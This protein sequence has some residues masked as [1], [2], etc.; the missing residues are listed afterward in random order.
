M[1]LHWRG[2]GHTRPKRTRLTRT[3]AT[4]TTVA[5]AAVLALGNAAHAGDPVD[6][7]S[8]EL[9]DKLFVASVR[10]HSQ[11]NQ[12]LKDLVLSTEM[13]GYRQLHPT[14]TLDQMRDHTAVMSQWY[15]S[16]LTGTDAAR[17]AYELLPHMLNMIALHPEA[18]IAAPIM[19]EL[20]DTVVS[21]DAKAYGER[22]DQVATAQFEYDQ[23]QRLYP[24]QDMIWRRI[25]ALA[26]QDQSFSAAWDGSFGAHLGVLS[27]ASLDQ[28]AADPMIS[29]YLNVDAILAHQQNTEQYLAEAKAQLLNA[30]HR[31]EEQNTVMV[32]TVG[33]LNAA[34][35]AT[36]IGPRPDTTVFNRERD[37]AAARQKIID[38]AGSAV[39]VLAKLIGYVDAKSGRIAA[40]LGKAAVQIATSINKYIP[41]IAGLS[42]GQALTSMST[43]ALTG[44][45][46]G[47]IGALLPV[48][49]EQVTPEQMIMDQIHQLRQE[50]GALATTMQSRF[51]RVEHALTVVYTDM[52]DKFD[53]VI[54]LQNATLAQL[55]ELERG[56]YQLNTTVDNWGVQIMQSLQ[57]GQLNAVK[58]RINWGI[59]HKQTYGEPIQ[60]YGDYQTVE[61][62]LHLMATDTAFNP[63]FAGPDASTYASQNPM[64]VLQTYQAKGAVDYLDWYARQ[65]FGWQAPQVNQPADVVPWIVAARAY[66][67]LVAENPTYARQVNQ[68][69]TGSILGAGQGIINSTTQ[70][71]KPLSTPD[72]N[73]KRTNALFTGLSAEYRAALQ[74]FSGQL[75]AIRGTNPGGKTYNMFGNGDQFTAATLPDAAKMSDPTKVP[76][77]TGTGPSLTRPSTVTLNGTPASL[78]FAQYAHPDAPTVKLCYSGG[79][80]NVETYD[81]IKWHHE[82]ADLQVI[83][84]V[85]VRWAGQEYDYRAWSMTWNLGEVCR[86]YLSGAPG[87]FCRNS[88][89]YLNQWDANY[90]T[91]FTNGALD[92]ANYSLGTM[93]RDRMNEYLS[94][95]Q[96]VYYDRVLGALGD[97]NSA[98]F[99]AD[100]RLSKA[101]RLIQAYTQLGFAKALIN[102]DVLAVITTGIER[103]PTDLDGVQ[104]IT[105][106]FAKAQA[107]YAGCNPVTPGGA[108]APGTGTFNPLA[109]QAYL[110]TNCN[111]GNPAGASGDPIG[112]CVLSI[113]NVRDAVYDQRIEQHSQEL[114][115]G[116]YAEGLPDV[117]AILEELTL[118]DTVVRR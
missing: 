21:P 51:D 28:L 70:F 69:R 9:R 78:L 98:L 67:R 117:L 46:I 45:I 104:F 108:C 48:F 40:G 15:D 106:S 27:T 112:D 12:G 115:T 103:L 84:R 47:A 55:A 60:S 79:L 93:A 33:Q 24:V 22:L 59:G 94:G 74:N 92:Q 38:G 6:V 96:K 3:L 17:Q 7:D 73:G 53:E 19:K 49:A 110:P 99:A 18:A 54:E 39:E 72:A 89:Y 62:P 11:G 25:T 116:V 76:P 20:L 63:P 2:L 95:R 111:P 97:S 80:A 113:G 57:Q 102:D 36:G 52:L 85:W 87:G 82:Y 83:I 65:Y 64:T 109:G 5:V 107:N 114:A 8:Q 91:G 101:V 88:A 100:A 37:A 23:F 4:V 44:N 26:Q 35:P 16:K 50:V 61:N 105:S 118:A 77:C 29:V 14:F 34:Y 43:V 58:E 31:L 81:D 41:S 1:K 13:Y 42:L 30:M 56:L 32:S 71:S 68:A 90:L 75:A 66:A 10:L 86:Q